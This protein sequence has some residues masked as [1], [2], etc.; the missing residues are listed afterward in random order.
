MPYRTI[1][2]WPNK[3]LEASA[4][5][6]SIQEI[7]E[8]SV[9]LIDTLRVA[10]GAGLA[11]PQINISK[12]V[13]VIDTSRFES[14]NPDQEKGDENFWVIANPK[15]SNLQGEFEWKE[16]CLSVPLVACFV[17]RSETLT[18]EYDDINGESNVIDLTPPLSLAVQHE[19][20][21]LDGK[22]ILN[23]ISRFKANMH[24]RKN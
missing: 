1:K 6:A 24:K 3:C 21:H 7:K 17:K 12:R 2:Q 8:I 16:A 20:D 15:M 14:V 9:D 5:T 4:E 22:T 19:V 13:L 10:V 11:A 18:L 23:R